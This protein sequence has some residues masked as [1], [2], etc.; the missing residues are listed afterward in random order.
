[1]FRSVGYVPPRVT[2][3]R[4]QWDENTDTSILTKDELKR[5]RNT[6]RQRKRRAEIYEDDETREL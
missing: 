2:D 4:I 3:Q 6:M 5:F 1:M